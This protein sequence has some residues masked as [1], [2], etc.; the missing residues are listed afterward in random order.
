MIIS[1]EVLVKS[2][3]N[4]NLDYYKSLG[5]NVNN[6][7]FS[8]C[9]E[10]LLKNSFSLV[11]VSCDYCNKIEEIPY[12][13]WNR[14]MCSVVKKYACSRKCT[15]QK[16]KES[17][18]FN[19]GVTSLSKL[20]KTKEKTRI[21]NTERWGVENVF[22][23][24]IVKDKIKSSNIE[25]FG[26]DNPM[27]SEYIKRKQIDKMLINWG[28]DNASKSELLK[29]KKR[30]TTF[31]NWGVYTPLQNDSLKEKYKATNLIKYGKEYFTQSDIYRRENYLISNDS[32]YISYI[33]DGIS[34]FKC[35]CLMDHTFEINKD[36]YSKRKKYNVGLCTICN[37]I[38]DN[39]SIK[40]KNLLDFIKSIY[41][42]DII[43]SYRIN[44]KEIDIYLPDLKI[45]FEFNGLYWHSDKFKDKK[46][47]IDIFHIWEDDWDYKN[48]IIKSQI[49]NRLNMN[50]NSIYARKCEIK[51]VP[52]KDVRVFMD[53]NH[54]QGYVNSNF[55]IGLYYNDE[56]ISIMTFD[57]F[58]GRK[59]MN[60]CEWN[61]NRFC[62]KRN[63]SVIGGASKL[64]NFFISFK[65][66]TRIISYADKDWS[67]GKLYYKLGFNLLSESKSD[68]KFVV[69]SKRVHKSN[70]K[71]GESS[72]NHMKIWDCGKIKFELVL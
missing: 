12:Y 54:I 66:P 71:K 64:L 46:L 14:S 59:R 67:S 25:K 61:L 47:G 22:E 52:T 10:D 50:Y 24:D 21:T 57:R 58:E 37:P 63:T 33:S 15:S 27:K 8:V 65:K 44:R 49:R 32:F 36:V 29:E 17:N 48:D 38:G 69:N 30:E 20:E 9:V 45:G 4:T 31:K 5:Y 1:R 72:L 28:V 51:E 40:E 19:H 42:K 53:E 60:D 2:K 23:S 34:L 55:K 68:Y 70:F 6:D 18:L 56:L 35:D 16:T 7:F 43:Q 62:T 11:K 39:K 41:D 3:Y 26:V 13:K